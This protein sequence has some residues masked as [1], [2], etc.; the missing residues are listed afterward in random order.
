MKPTSAAKGRDFLDTNVV[1]YLLSA[2]TAKADRAEGLL[3]RRP[4]ISVQVLNEV[5]NVCVRK[6]RMDWGETGQFL[7]LVRSFCWIVPLT[8]EVHDRARMIAEFPCETRLHSAQA[9]RP[10]SA[11]KK[12]LDHLACVQGF[13]SGI[14]WSG[15]G[16]NSRPSHCE[17]DA[18]PAELPPQKQ[19]R[20]Y[21]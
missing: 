13:L 15:G 1:L 18:L 10:D 7:D 12:A 8:V 6:L 16:S 4:V 21:T 2:D 14:W 11:N 20:N 19:D 17:R 3:L 5:T 9:P